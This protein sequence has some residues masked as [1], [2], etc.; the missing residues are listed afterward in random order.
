MTEPA[1]QSH[2][3]VLQRS[4]LK[5]YLLGRNL[6]W[7]LAPVRGPGLCGH[8]IKRWNRIKGTKSLRCLLSF[9]AHGDGS[10]FAKVL[11]AVVKLA[12]ARHCSLSCS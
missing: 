11:R 12:G 10:C 8:M 5:I 7:A 3:N 9:V 2:A 6:G 4:K 1:E